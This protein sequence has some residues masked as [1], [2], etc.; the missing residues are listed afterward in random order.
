MNPTTEAIRP[1]PRQTRPRPGETV[2]SFVH[3]LARTNH[4]RPS[5]L[6]RLLLN[7]RNSP[8][9]GSINLTRLAALTGRNAATLGRAFQAAEPSQP[10][11]TPV[12]KSTGRRLRRQSDK[13]ELFAE[14]R[15]AARKHDLSIRA[16]ADR[17]RVHR[18]T[19]RQALTASSPPAPK[20]PVRRSYALHGLHRHIDA[21]LH[22]DPGI[23]AGHIWERLIDEYD[24]TVSYSTLRGYVARQRHITQH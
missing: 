8:Y 17:F 6:R 3:R 15:D 7:N 13:P 21:M 12:G 20:K 22:A 1:L 9:G 23:P 19:I 11:P 4:L 14:I 5:H 18:R 10:G 2:E 16:L 24:A